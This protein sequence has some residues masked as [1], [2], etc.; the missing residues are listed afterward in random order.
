MSFSLMQDRVSILL[1]CLMP[2]WKRRVTFSGP[3]TLGMLFGASSLKTQ[4]LK[5]LQNQRALLSPPG[6]LQMSI[7]GLYV[8]LVFSAPPSL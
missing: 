3:I 5:N 4:F 6:V 1:Y 2:V 7:L 8:M